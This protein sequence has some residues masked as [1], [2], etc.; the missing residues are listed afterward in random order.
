MY[1]FG[2]FTLVGGGTLA[3]AKYDPEFRKLLAEYAPFTD[4]VIK[5]VFQ[6]EGS[7]FEIISATVGNWKDAIITGFGGDPRKSL[8]DVKEIPI[9]YKRKLS[10]KIAVLCSVCY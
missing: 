10:V 4:N 2:A 6:E 9:D 5:F 7:I 8:K 1:T 3:Y